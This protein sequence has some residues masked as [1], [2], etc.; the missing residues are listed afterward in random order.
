MYHHACI[1]K[2]FEVNSKCPLCKT[3]YIGKFKDVGN[4]ENNER[5]LIEIEPLV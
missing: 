2:W 1:S 5:D 4:R 3:D